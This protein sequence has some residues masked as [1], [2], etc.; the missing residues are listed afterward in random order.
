MGSQS[1]T[2]VSG[3]GGNCGAG[4]PGGGAGGWFGTGAAG[5]WAGAGGPGGWAGGWFGAMLYHLGRLA[6]RR[7]WWVLA[8][9]TAVVLG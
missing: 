3:T 5:G 9:W 6:Y 1:S 8:V 4:G 7:R 2:T